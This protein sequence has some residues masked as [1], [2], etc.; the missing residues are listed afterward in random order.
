MSVAY[1]QDSSRQT[2]APVVELDVLIIGAGIS[3]AST[4]YWLREA[5]L[6]VGIVD[7]GDACAGA[8]G[9]N[10]GFVTCGSVE[11][12]SRQVRTHG[13]ETALGLWSLCQDNLALIEA[14][15]ADGLACDFRR[16]GTYSLAGSKHELDELAATAEQLEGVGVKVSVHGAEHVHQT[17]QARHFAGGVLYH[18]DGEVHPVKLVKGLLARS[19]AELFAHHE[20]FDLDLSGD[21]VVARSQHRV[22]KAPVVV[23]ATNGYSA[24]LHPWFAEKIYPTRGQIMVTQPVPRFLHAP[25]YAN[26]VLDYFRQLP[27]GRMLIGGFRQL[28]KDQETGTADVVHPEIQG[29]LV[30]FLRRHFPPLAELR[31]DYQWSGTMGFSSDSLPMIGALPGRSNAFILGGYTGHGIGWGV[32]AGQ[33]L[34]ELMLEGKQPPY[35]SARRF[36]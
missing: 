3:G 13:E 20:I 23:F 4:A 1:W 14:L 29:A 2:T 15:Q 5:G 16:N 8:S 33:L 9:R 36:G 11:H 24:D 26:F 6:R 30:S 22:F 25:C 27:D 12:Y 35:V 34:A 17:L 32:K 7:R 21:G 28:A 19:G 18:D 10:A 31:I